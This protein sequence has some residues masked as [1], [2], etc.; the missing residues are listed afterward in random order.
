MFVGM[1]NCLVFPGYA[2]SCGKGEIGYEGDGG[3]KGDEGVE[4]A[5]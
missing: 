1:L 4:D 5:F 3:Y 2:F